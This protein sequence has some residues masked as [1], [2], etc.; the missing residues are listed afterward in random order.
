MFLSQGYIRECM[1]SVPKYTTLKIE[2]YCK[3]KR[4]INKPQ[5][6]KKSTNFTTDTK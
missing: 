3:K 4:K 1:L 6:K 2:Q 5:Q